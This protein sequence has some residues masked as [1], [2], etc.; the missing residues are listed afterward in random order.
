M[1]RAPPSPATPIPLG[2]T[3]GAR[4]IERCWTKPLVGA[5]KPSPAMDFLSPTATMSLP[6]TTP[7]DAP[8]ALSRAGFHRGHGP[9]GL[10]QLTPSTAA[11]SSTTTRRR[12][13]RNPDP[14]PAP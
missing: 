12:P 13:A 6:C 2:R 10:P 7:A 5:R 9:R 14:D 8:Q 11:P 3:G 1:R 4:R